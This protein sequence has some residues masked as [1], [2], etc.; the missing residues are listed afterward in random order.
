VAEATKRCPFCAEEILAAAIRCKHCKSDLE[1]KS[2]SAP[3]T[4]APHDAGADDLIEKIPGALERRLGALL[5]PGETVRVKLRGVFKEALVCTDQRVVIL[6]TGFMTGHLFGANVFQVAYRN[7]TS[8]QVNTH[9]LSGYFEVS[10]G[11][12]QNV[13]TSYWSRGK[14]SPQQRD[15]CVSLGRSLFRKFERAAG[16]VLSNSG[17]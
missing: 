17:R 1:E 11:G 8:A 12:V 16:F 2:S 14:S 4:T 10:A 9:L 13:V 5:Q 15:N 7:V 3:R 6:K